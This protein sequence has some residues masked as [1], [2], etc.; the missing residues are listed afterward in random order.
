MKLAFM[1]LGCPN[2]DLDTI[3]ARGRA[4]GFDGVDFRGYLDTIDI[5]LRSE[6]TRGAAATRRQLNDAG[7]E[8]SAISS[9]IQVCVPDK[10]LANLE[11]AQRTIEVARALGAP[12]VRIFGGGDLVAHSLDGLAH[13]G[14]ETIEQILALDGAAD[15]HWL[16][17]THD[18]WVKAANCRLLLDS[19]P[20]P[21][22]GALWDMGHT[23]RVGEEQPAE[24]FE[25]L[26][27]RVGYAHV[28]DALY[29]PEHPQAMG[30]GWR[31]VAPGSGQLPLAESIGILKASGYDGWLQFEHEK[32]WHPELPE[33]DEIFPKFVCWVRG[34]L[35]N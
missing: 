35:E 4:Y 10:L 31:Y 8:V 24:T 32:R 22:F 17:E 15:L 34:V 6:F 7:L 20:N 11:E 25:A 16:F 23:Y 33:P 29:D 1:T 21:A 30:D 19:I 5:T 26:S 2:W 12:N 13:V 18:L 28:K 14:R 3:C 27:G 9:S